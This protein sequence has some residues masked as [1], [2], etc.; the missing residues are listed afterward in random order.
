M[1][2]PLVMSSENTGIDFLNKTLNGKRPIEFKLDPFIGNQL[3]TDKIFAQY[4]F[5]ALKKS[6]HK[7]IAEPKN[8]QPCENG[9]AK[10]LSD[11]FNISLIIFFYNCFRMK[12]CNITTCKWFMHIH[13]FHVLTTGECS[14]IA[15]YYKLLLIYH[16]S[17]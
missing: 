15:P 2:K 11:T 7:K 1:F 10:C 16:A 3:I 17:W 13:A 6:V 12:M 14:Q 8:K 9:C 4:H 5:I